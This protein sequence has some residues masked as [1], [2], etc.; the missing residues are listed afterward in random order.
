MEAKATAKL[1]ILLNR[2]KGVAAPI[3]ILNSNITIWNV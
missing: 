3:N 1:F 2:V